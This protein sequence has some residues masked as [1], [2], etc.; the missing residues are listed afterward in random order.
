MST[1]IILLFFWLYGLS[2]FAFCFMVSAAFSRARV[3][4]TVGAVIFLLSFFPFYAVSGDDVSSGNKGA[5][6]LS[7]NICFALGAATAIKFESAQQGITNANVNTELNNFRFGTTIGMFIFDLFF[8]MLLALYFERVVPSTYGIS[9]KWN[10]CC[11][12]SYWRKSCKYVP[13]AMYYQYSDDDADVIHRCIRSCNKP[14]AG[15]DAVELS[16]AASDVQKGEN[17]SSNPNIEPP[18]ADLAPLAKVKVRGLRK[19]FPNLNPAAPPIVAVNNVSLDMYEGQIF[20]LLGHNGAGKTTTINIL[21]GM[22]P[23]SGGN[24]DIYGHSLQTDLSE[25][26]Q[27]L[28]VCPQH[29]ILFDLLTVREHLVLFAMLKGELSLAGS[30]DDG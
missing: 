9:L 10:F 3:A 22:Y 14:A 30:I 29:N 21:T 8:Y 7:T 27:S 17:M 23:S 1:S 2:I 20:A 5:A 13:A 19:E 4:S 6:C 25:I 26:R 15:S 16:A 12:P 11:R 28:G 18:N 24:A